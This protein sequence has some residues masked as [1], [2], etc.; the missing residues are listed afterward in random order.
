MRSSLFAPDHHW[1]W[2][3]W[4]TD[5]AVLSLVVFW[6]QIVDRL[7]IF[8]P[9]SFAFLLIIFFVLLLRSI[10][11]ARQ[12]RSYRIRATLPVVLH[13]VTLIA[14]GYVWLSAAYID[15]NFQAHAA[16]FV[17]IVQL[18]ERRQ[19]QLPPNHADD[20]LL[21]QAYQALTLNGT[22]FIDGDPPEAAITFVRYRRF[23]GYAAIA[24]LPDDDL[25]IA[26]RAAP[27]RQNIQ[28]Q[29]H[30]FWVDCKED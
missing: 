6:E 16:D 4:F 11:Y 29:P 17:T 22:F 8:A 7:S 1:A 24:Y 23:A 21:P 26:C 10:C 19:L 9:L 13:L 15:W 18:V 12:Q 25:S 28:L 27:A 20:I 14:A 30:W 2:M 3:A 5:I